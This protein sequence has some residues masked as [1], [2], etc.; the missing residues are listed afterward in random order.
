VILENVLA[1]KPR[2]AALAGA[3][4]LESQLQAGGH[5]QG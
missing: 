2:N 3:A 4:A 5:P 1:K